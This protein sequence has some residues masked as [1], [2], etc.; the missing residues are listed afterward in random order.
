L[1]SDHSKQ[2]R[3]D[4]LHTREQ[5]RN[6]VSRAPL[7]PLQAWAEDRPETD[8]AADISARLQGPD[9]R[10][11]SLPIDAALESAD[12]STEGLT[13]IALPPFK[14]EENA[15][16]MR[17]SADF[18]QPPAPP[19]VT[20]VPISF[21]GGDDSDEGEGVEGP[22]NSQKHCDAVSSP[23]PVSTASAQSSADTQSPKR[24]TPSAA[25]GGTTTAGGAVTPSSAAKR[26]SDAKKPVAE[27][28]AIRS[29]YD[30]EREL[31]LA[32]KDVSAVGRLLKR[33]KLSQ[34]GKV[35]SDL[36]EPSVLHLLLISVEQ[37][38]GERKRQ[39]AKVADWFAAVRECKRFPSQYALLGN[40]LKVELRA[41]LTRLRELEVAA[42]SGGAESVPT[43]AVMDALL[44]AYQ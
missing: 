14:A 42:D 10:P 33:L 6:A 2:V 44:S 21:D 37:Y 39:Y 16:S 35:L 19:A 27:L 41:V 40:E 1:F 38:Y 17:S 8:E 29:S 9:P 13:A 24:A 22:E 31:K 11:P 5:L 23:A 12:V 3:S 26:S 7:V 34:V 36:M 4:L 32:S 43:V 25:A 30:L 18:A 20:R 15:E 28:P